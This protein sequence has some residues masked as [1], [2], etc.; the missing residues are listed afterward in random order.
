MHMLLKGAATKMASIQAPSG[1]FPPFSH[2]YF[3]K[4][5]FKS[6]FILSGGAEKKTKKS[7]KGAPDEVK[8]CVCV[9]VCVCVCERA[10]LLFFHVTQN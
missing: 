4:L 7:Q 10:G 8:F 1:P 6:L 2:L 3:W 5:S 9:C